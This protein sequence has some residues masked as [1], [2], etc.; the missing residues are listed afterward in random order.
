[1]AYSFSTNTNPT[2]SAIAMYSLIATLISA[3][4]TK[5][6]DS[7][8][9]T[10][11]SSGV[12]VTSGASGTNGLANNSAWVQL[13]APSVGGQVRSITIQRGTVNTSWRVKYSAAAGFSGGSPAATVTPSATDEAIILGTGTDAS[14]TFTAWFPTDGTFRLNIACGGA[15]EKY[16]FYMMLFSVGNSATSTRFMFLDVLSSYETGDVDPAVIGMSNASTNN[17]TEFQNADHNSTNPRV[18]NGWMGATSNASNFVGL[19]LL[20]NGALTPHTGNGYGTN[21]FTSNDIQ[22]GGLIWARSAAVVAPIGP[23]G[24]SSL[25]RFNSTGRANAD[26]ITVSTT[27]DYIYYRGYILPWDGSTPSI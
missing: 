27:R 11:S 7:D 17:I 16:V 21:P 14:P 4:W 8:G 24:V 26:T 12:Q 2:T 22:F 18:A 6:K 20:V 13:A 25:F 10:Y 23:K 1:M 5:V 15:S 19:A 3:G 9:T